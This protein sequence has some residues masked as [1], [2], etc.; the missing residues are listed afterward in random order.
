MIII[1]RRM[2]S[3]KP[4]DIKVSRFKSLMWISMAVFNI[5]CSN[6]FYNLFHNEEV[7]EPFK[8]V[9]LAAFA[10]LIVYALY[11]SYYLPLVLKVH[12]CEDYNPRFIGIGAGA[13]AVA[14]LA[15]LIAI[16]PVW[17]FT[18]FWLLGIIWKGFWEL[19]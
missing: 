13:G 12:N 14:I 11:V 15:L 2:P 5:Y 1:I 17:G 18:S 4:H 19:A 9:S 3:K 7:R 8:S 6:F 10:F 16:W